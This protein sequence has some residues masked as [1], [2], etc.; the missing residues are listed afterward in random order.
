MKTFQEWIKEK[1]LFEVSKPIAATA[2][3]FLGGPLGAAV[4][5]QLGQDEKKPSSSKPKPKPSGEWPSQGM[6]DLSPEELLKKGV[7][8][9]KIVKD[10]TDATNGRSIETIWPNGVRSTKFIGRAKQV[11]RN[12]VNLSPEELLQQGIIQGELIKDEIKDISPGVK[13]RWITTKSNSGI[14]IIKFIGH[15]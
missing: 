13:Q 12:M 2:G 4:G 3:W 14:E 7:I 6:V 15:L 5:Y 1:K 11:P 10:I 8:E 9:G